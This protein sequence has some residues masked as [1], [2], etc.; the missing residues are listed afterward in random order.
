[1][2]IWDMKY[3]KLKVKYATIDIQYDYDVI[4][5][6]VIYNMNIKLKDAIY[7][8]NIKHKIY[9]WNNNIKYAKLKV[10]YAKLDIKKRV[11]CEHATLYMW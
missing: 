5:F 6:G 4:I 10:K 1:M 3:A 2:W 7:D 11:L 8:V 9:L